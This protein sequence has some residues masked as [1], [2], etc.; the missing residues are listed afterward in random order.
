MTTRLRMRQHSI[1]NGLMFEI[2]DGH[3]LVGRIYA[4]P[5]GI[6]VISKYPMTTTADD[7][8][9]NARERRI[10]FAERT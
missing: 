3:Q 5:R 6:R 8:E 1:T 4:A 7:S 9:S 2:W 10:N